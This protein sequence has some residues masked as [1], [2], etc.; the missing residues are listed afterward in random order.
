V[1]KSSPL[2]A[3]LF[4]DPKTANP[5]N[6]DVFGAPFGNALGSPDLNRCA[7]SNRELMATNVSPEFVQGT[8]GA[9]AEDRFVDQSCYAVRQNLLHDVAES[10]GTDEG[11]PQ[12]RIP[13][14]QA[15][16]ADI[17]NMTFEQSR[18]P[19]LQAEVDRVRRPAAARVNPEPY[20]RSEAAQHAMESNDH[21]LGFGLWLHIPFFFSHRVLAAAQPHCTSR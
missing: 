9:S 21:S 4:G 13:S 2:G 20:S 16:E 15:L 12:M 8:A 1:H 6:S 5:D 18:S 3:G 10:G 19:E 11:A 7:D 14:E 17:V